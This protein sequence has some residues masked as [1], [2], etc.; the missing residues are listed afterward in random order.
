[1]VKAGNGAGVAAGAGATRRSSGTA[2][3]SAPNAT[4]HQC[5]VRRWAGDHAGIA[6]NHARVQPPQQRRRVRHA[7][8]D[9]QR[10]EHGQGGDRGAAVRGQRLAEPVRAEQAA[11]QVPQVRE[12]AGDEH[13]PAEGEDREGQA[14]AH[15]P[16]QPGVERGAAAQPFEA[17]PQALVGAP[18]DE[19]PVGAVP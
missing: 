5:A 4:P 10:A 14:D 12:V 11:P 8:R 7:E 1:V 17:Q 13:R 6:S 18:E 9:R 2:A 16:G 19:R 3:I 15:R